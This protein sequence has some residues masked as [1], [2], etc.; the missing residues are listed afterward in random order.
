MKFALQASMDLELE[1]SRIQI[2][3]LK[4]TISASDGEIESSRHR[5]APSQASTQQ[6]LAIIDKIARLEGVISSLEDD[7]RLK[8]ASLERF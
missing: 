2:E 5:L 4:A 7:K 1:S 8:R 6:D 3:Q